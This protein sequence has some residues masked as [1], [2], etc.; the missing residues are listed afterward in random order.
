METIGVFKRIGLSVLV[1]GTLFHGAADAACSVTARAAIPL[2]MVNNL[3]IV[4][5]EV[6]GIA[7]S[8]VL[9]T[10][11]K[12]SMVTVEAVHRL[13]LARDQWIDTP[14]AGIGGRGSRLANADPRSLTLGGIPLARRLF[15]H[16]ASLAVSN[17]HIGRGSG[18]VIDGLLGGD[19]LSVFDLDLDEAS[20]VLTLFSVQGCSGRFLPW[21]VG[22]TSIPV[23]FLIDDA[24]MVQV[25]VDGVP[26]WAMLDTGAAFSSLTAAAMIRLG[27]DPAGLAADPA[28][29]AGG[30]GFRGVPVRLHRFRSLEIAGEVMDPP[31][32]WVGPMSTSPGIGMLLGED[33]LAK[34]RIWISYATSQV[35]VA[36]R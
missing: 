32:I 27:L 6:N 34:R 31:L 30:V 28:L 23:R 17:L 20:R 26:L 16:D 1:A 9:D 29:T 5:V 24:I 12:R 33:W 11:A 18:P 13:G 36:G 2:D 15:R 22:Y 4:P 7:A 35:F 10:G 3:V 21:P 25:A 19:F 8:F 14:V